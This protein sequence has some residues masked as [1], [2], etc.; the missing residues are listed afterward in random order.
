MSTVISFIVVLGIL[1]FVHELGHFLAAKASGVRVLKFSLGFGP[2]L[3]G[4]KVGHTDYMISAIPLGGYVRMLGDDPTAD[5]GPEE[6]PFSF[7]TQGTLKK[8]FIVAAGPVANFLFAVFALWIVFMLGIPVLESVVGAV[9]ENSPAE[10]AGL[11]AEDRITSID[12][13]SITEWEEMSR[14]IQESGGEELALVVERSTDGET[15]ELL[16]HITPELREGTNELMLPDEVYMIGIS[17][18]DSYHYDRKGPIGAIGA[19]VY[20]TGRIVGITFLVIGKMFSGDVPLNNLG[21]PILIAQVSAEAFRLGLMEFL[22]FLALISI[23]LGILN[24]LPVPILDGG[25]L[26]FFVIEGVIGRP[27]HIR[28]KEIALQIGL[29]LL[30]AL[31]AMAFYFD[32]ARLI[33]GD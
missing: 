24:L 29:V 26:A 13:V 12:G 30:V 21:G 18:S 5:L 17:M 28:I 15:E 11:V 32:I 10:R 27:I 31:M 22:Y 7:L 2:R 19:S 4:K 25:H 14:L 9:L 1:I 8:I 6:A 33:A 20:E 16:I 23:N 3:I